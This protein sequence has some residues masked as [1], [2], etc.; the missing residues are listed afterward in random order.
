[1]DKVGLVVKV[2]EFES[3]LSQQARNKPGRRH[4]A[5]EVGVKGRFRSQSVADTK[6]RS[7]CSK[8]KEK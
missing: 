4:T 6:T 3:V 7:D 8:H 1:V 5:L 2:V